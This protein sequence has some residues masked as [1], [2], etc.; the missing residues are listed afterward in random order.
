VNIETILAEPQRFLGQSLDLEAYFVGLKEGN[1]YQAYLG[2]NPDIP[3]AQKQQISIAHPFAELKAMIRPLPSMQLLY[4]GNLTNPPYYYRFP[5]RLTARVEMNGAKTPV[6]QDISEV[7]VQV[8]Y[9]GKLAELT[10]YPSYE[11]TATIDYAPQREPET[12]RLAKAKVMAK[13]HLLLAEIDE[14]PLILSTDDNRYVRW[15]TG[16]NLRFGGWLKSFRDTKNGDS[17]FVLKSF[18]IRSSMVAVGPLKEMS[19]IWLRPSPIYALLS[20]HMSINPE[21]E[22]HQRVDVTG[23]IDYLQEEVPPIESE[24]IPKLVFT[25][26]SA[27]T[28]YEEAYLLEA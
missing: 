23:K 13:R 22:L 10:P 27:I 3:D 6:L 1:D 5:I 7:S 17:H 14:A 21:T 8:P 12:Q 19:G 9:S 18:A 20:A 2:S 16:Q 11:Y 28:I 26:L 25:E 24:T 15:M 4:R